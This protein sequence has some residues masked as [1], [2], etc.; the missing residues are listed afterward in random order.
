[1]INTGASLKL[2]RIVGRRWLTVAILA[3]NKL[4]SPIFNI[5]IS[6]AVIRIHSAAVWGGF[7]YFLLIAN[8]LVTLIS[9]GHQDYLI[10]TFSKT[11]QNIISQWTQNLIARSSIF[12]GCIP[13][14]LIFTIS[15][16][17]YI[18]LLLWVF[19]LYIY[20]SY[21]V[22]IVYY[23]N[24]NIT[25]LLEATGSLGLI[26]LITQLS[27]FSAF[28]L[29][30]FHII[31]NTLKIITVTF[32]FYATTQENIKLKLDL[33]PLI[34]SFPFFLPSLIGFIQSRVDMFIVAFSLSKPE[35]AKY[36]VLITLLSFVHQAALL[37]VVPYTK[38]IYRL[39]DKTINGLAKI[40]FQYGILV[41]LLAVP[42]VYLAVTYYYGSSLPL[43]TYVISFFTLL[44]LFYYSIKTY[45][46]FKHNKQYSVVGIN[47]MMALTTFLITLMLI[48][49][50]G[51]TGALIA[52]CAAQWIALLIFYFKKTKPLPS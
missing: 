12:L 16:Y 22:L 37:I 9:W 21:D 1:M 18:I 41:S 17:E 2:K 7:V 4:S 45:Q 32:Y 42:I 31:I 51:I 34:G 6:F 48:P 26:V 3:L 27:D 50:L 30:T 10:K 29:I 28:K 5:I 35:L 38:N 44:P 40:F 52:N 23:R 15:A 14:L 47:C 43:L 49:I 24:F 19:T 20:R 33:K 8:L 39:P 46:W 13:V 25:F 36:Q 11:P